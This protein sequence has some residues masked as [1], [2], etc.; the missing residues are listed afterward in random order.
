MCTVCPVCHLRNSCARQILWT[1]QFHQSQNRVSSV[2]NLTC[3]QEKEFTDTGQITIGLWIRWI[4]ISELTGQL[5]FK[6]YGYP[7]DNCCLINRFGLSSSIFVIYFT[8]MLCTQKE[9]TLVNYTSPHKLHRIH[10]PPKKHE[11]ILWWRPVTLTSVCRAHTAVKPSLS[12][13][14]FC[15]L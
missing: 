5:N 15:R 4:L 3:K 11:F 1:A 12:F 2:C 6:N 10:F 14:Y 9:L 13:C 7:F 8:E